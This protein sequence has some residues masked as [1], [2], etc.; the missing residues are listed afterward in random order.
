MVGTGQF[1]L[2][3]FRAR[4]QKMSDAELIRFGKAARYLSDPKNG[5]VELTYIWQSPTLYK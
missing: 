4:L 5:S 2:E 3:E 1:D